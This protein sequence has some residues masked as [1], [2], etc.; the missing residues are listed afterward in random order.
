M[1]PTKQINYIHQ[2]LNLYCLVLPQF[3]LP[4]AC[5]FKGNVYNHYLHFIF[6]LK[7]EKHKFRIYIF[8]DYYSINQQTK[9]TI[10]LHLG[11][12]IVFWSQRNTETNFQD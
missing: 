12:Q 7:N 4:T 6:S 2:S 11:T 5:P 10:K 1:W 3:Q 8:S 9:T